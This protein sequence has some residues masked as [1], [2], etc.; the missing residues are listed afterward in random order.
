[1][2]K[3]TFHWSCNGG[4]NSGPSTGPHH[5]QLERQGQRSCGFCLLFS[6]LDFL[7]LSMFPN[8][9]LPLHD[10]DGQVPLSINRV[11]KSAYS[12]ASGFLGS[13]ERIVSNK[14]VIYNALA[15]MCLHTVD[16][17][18]GSIRA[19]YLQTVFYIPSSMDFLTSI[20]HR[21][22]TDFLRVPSAAL[23]LILTGYLIKKYRPMAPKLARWNIIATILAIC[24]IFITVMIKCQR[25]RLYASYNNRWLHN[26]LLTLPCWLQSFPRCQT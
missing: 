14:M 10:N 17:N 21:F 24:I 12:H 7:T 3:S 25:T 9:L 19:S 6:L 15:S 2:A 4:Q 11:N 16:I 5:I 1:M 20:Q 18:F 22:I 13:L 23:V 26:V 8:K